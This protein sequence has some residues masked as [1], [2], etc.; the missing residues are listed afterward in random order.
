M[1]LYNQSVV[2]LTTKIIN[3]FS[4]VE[5]Q[6]EHGSDKIALCLYELVWAHIHEGFDSLC[7][8]MDN[9]AGQN[10]N[11]YIVLMFMFLIQDG[12]VGHSFLPCDHDFGV[13][14]K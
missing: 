12:V 13:P 4:W 1:W 2:N 3:Y 11:I 8:I 5:T 14:E 6:A 7:V 9:C 10:K